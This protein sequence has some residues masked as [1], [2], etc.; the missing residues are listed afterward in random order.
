MARVDSARS[1][2]RAAL[3]GAALALL[4]A[5][6]HAAPAGAQ[7]Y[8][9]TSDPQFPRLR[10]ADSLN[11]VNDRC[12]VTRHRLNPMIAPIYVNG[13]PVGFC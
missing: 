5:A 4:L 12:V 9:P 8:V 10:Y 3:G 11:S 1:G 6:A 7:R 2:F 13:E